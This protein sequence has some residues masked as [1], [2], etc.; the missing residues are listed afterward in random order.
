MP[1]P[2]KTYP[3][4]LV[5]TRSYQAAIARAAVGDPV[6]ILHETGNPHDADAL[7][8][9]DGAGDALGYIPRSSWLRRALVEEGRGCRAIVRT[10]A[11]AEATDEWEAGIW[12]TINVTLTDDGAIS[13]R[14]YSTN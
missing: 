4:R 3:V 14:A 10:L 11:T 8:V 2:E 7:V 9:V 6:A 13:A 1:K 12:A 5:G